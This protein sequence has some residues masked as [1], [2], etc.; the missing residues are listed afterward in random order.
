MYR[1]SRIF[2]CPHKREQIRDMTIEEFHL[3]KFKAGGATSDQDARTSELIANWDLNPEA[4]GGAPSRP[5]NMED[6]W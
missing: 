1:I 2:M 3:E 5:W 4:A 6:G